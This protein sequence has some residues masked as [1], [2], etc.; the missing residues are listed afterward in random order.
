MAHHSIEHVVP[1]RL[2]RDKGAQNDTVHLFVTDRRINQFRRD[3]RFGHYDPSQKGWESCGSTFRCLKKRLFFPS[4]SHR[5]IAHTVWVM[6]S[7]YPY[8]Q[9]YEDQCFESLD[10]W[11]QWLAVPW[12]PRE[13]WILEKK[14][15]L[16]RGLCRTV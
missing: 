8:L 15:E 11:R 14:E 6:M 7:K 1:A 5:L 9:Q 4:H 12:T 2:F 16:V 13:R 3:Y 10:V